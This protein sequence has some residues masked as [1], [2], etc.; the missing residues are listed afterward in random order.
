VNNAW[1]DMILLLRRERLLAAASLNPGATNQEVENLEQHLSIELPTA[2][3]EFLSE[4][5]GQSERAKVGVYLGSRINSTRDIRDQWDSWRS[6]DE[7]AMNVDCADFMSSKPEGV[8]KPM[9]TNRLWIPLTHDFGGNHVGLDFDP[10]YK[11]KKGQ[12]IRF[13]RDVDQK[14]LVADSF[15]EFLNE[16]IAELRAA[17]WSFANM[18][19]EERSG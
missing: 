5:N 6:I 13:G 10:G 8:V 19:R 4:H 3:G 7:E 15:D 2:V 9:Y 16:M 1:D 11:G 14:V 18:N 17:D 12:V